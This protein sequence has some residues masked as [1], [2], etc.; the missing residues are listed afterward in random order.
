MWV[1]ITARVSAP[2]PHFVDGG[3]GDQQYANR[4][5]QDGD[6]AA[7]AKAARDHA[8]ILTALAGDPA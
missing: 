2:E 7:E 4:H 1:S 6:I 8:A 5:A 3:Q